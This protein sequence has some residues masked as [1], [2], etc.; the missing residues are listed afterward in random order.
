MVSVKRPK[1]KKSAAKSNLD[2]LRHSTSHVL[3]AAVLQLFPDAQLGIGP[4]I[5]EGFYYD[6]VL[7]RTL[8][9][10]DLPI[11]EHKMREIVERK[12]PFQKRTAKPEEALAWA[13]KNNQPFKAELIKELPKNEEISFYDLGD[14]FT[15]LCRGPHVK[16]TSEIKAFKLLRV[17]GAYWKGD[18]KRPQM[19]RIYGTAFKT[20]KELEE[21]LKKLA[22]A[23]KR[24]HRKLGRE[25]DLFSISEAVGAGLILW[26]AK[27][28]VIRQIIEDF[29]KEEHQKRGYQYQYTPHIGNLNLWKTSG[30]WEF[31][32][33][34][35]YSPM[36]ID[37]VEYLVK[38]MNCP[39]HIQIYKTR[40]HSYRELPLRV[41]ELGT[42]YR[43]EKTGVLSG[44]TRVR[45]FTQ[46]D[47]HIFCTPEQLRSEVE[48]VLDL[49]LFMLKSFGFD[50]YVFEL[51]VRDPAEQKKYLGSREIWDKAE[52]AL[53]KVL[54]D[55]KIKYK[56]GV[57]EAKFYGPAID[58]KLLDA[59]GREW[60]GP[61]I[62]VDFNL[63]LKFDVNFVAEDGKEHKVVMIHRT[64]LGSMERFMGVL[65]EHYAGAF[66][67]WLAPV[68]VVVLPVADRHF[69]YAKQIVIKL[70][71][72][73]IRAE[74]NLRSETL[75]ARIREAE[76]QKIPYILV[77]GDKE[78]SAKKVAVRSR[79]KG[80]EGQL[81]LERFVKRLSGEIEKKNN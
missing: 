24:D 62:Q 5:E 32:R 10:D 13:K 38:P 57:G 1:I 26:H 35:M 2:T 69:D 44:L 17:S 39:F 36:K 58:I 31:Y 77:V 15:D 73:K 37:E 66:P 33:E 41:A 60:Q 4:T 46:D 61:T 21:Y 52:E 23:E 80:D 74:A 18:E 22:E 71:K 19:Q 34:N 45:G 68:Q 65:I 54:Q 75:G 42:V 40:T 47:A 55:R 53:E 14:I 67:L 29:W 78:L 48:G 6:F 51:S 16:N 20:E 81:S 7:P 30:H 63:P 72:E 56:T 28:S 79:K 11:I 12:L 49:A 43:Y 3:A 25:L 9:P 64:V 76:L 27:G 50:E 59:L 70:L 8:T